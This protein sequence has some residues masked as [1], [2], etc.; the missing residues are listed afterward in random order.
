MGPITSQRPHTIRV[1]PRGSLG[2]TVS[3]P[4]D[5]SLSHRAIIFGA[6]ANGTSRVRNWLP[7]GDT[8]ATLDCVRALGVTVEQHEQIVTVHGR[9]L[10]G[11]RA[12]QRALNCVNA[13]TGMRL[14]AGVLAGQPFASTLDGSAQL[15]RRPMRRIIDPLRQMGA[16]V[17][18][19]ND[20]APLVF[21]PAD[22]HGITYA[23]PVASAQVKSCVLLAGL[24]ADAPTTVVE[25]GPA[26]DHTERLLTAMGASLHTE[27]DRVTIAPGAR[28][29]VE[30]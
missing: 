11:L 20:R 8:L 12:P 27:G 29:T 21:H 17:Q 14:L 7:A 24:F 26:R 30:K 2:G 6:L 15:R 5:K 22:L 25:P 9:G 13:G 1:Q 16:D 28:Y 19:E 18:A 4:G 3:V 10:H 23:M